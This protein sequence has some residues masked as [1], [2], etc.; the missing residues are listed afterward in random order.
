MN[1]VWNGKGRKGRERDGRKEK[2]GNQRRTRVG[3]NW[4]MGKMR[5]GE[6]TMD[7]NRKRGKMK[8]GKT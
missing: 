2:R 8:T 5:T 4:K 6:K 1:E 7:E 3:M